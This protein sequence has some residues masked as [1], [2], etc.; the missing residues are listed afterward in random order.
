V[1]PLV[2]MVPVPSERK[3]INSREHLIDG[4]R[5]EPEAIARDRFQER[6]DPR[7]GPRPHHIGNDVRVN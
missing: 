1:E 5:R 6:G 7:L 4:D 2:E 3:T